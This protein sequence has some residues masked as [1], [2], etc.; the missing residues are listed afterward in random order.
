MRATITF[1]LLFIAGA[2]VA[3][4]WAQG[5]GNAPPPAHS[6]PPG[7]RSLAERMGGYRQAQ[8]TPAPPL[9][10]EEVEDAP[11][12]LPAPAAA[13]PVAPSHLHTE[14]NAPGAP[15]PLTIFLTDEQ[16]GEIMTTA[17]EEEGTLERRL[18]SIRGSKSPSPSPAPIAGPTPRA[19]GQAPTPATAAPEESDTDDG[20]RRVSVLR[21]ST[22]EHGSGNEPTPLT[23]S[24]ARPIG[25]TPAS[26]QDGSGASGIS[27]R[28]I[29]PHV[30][31]QETVTPRP[32]Q[33][34]SPSVAATPASNAIFSSSG[35]S[36]S[37]EA[38]GPKTLSVGKP[39]TYTIKLNNNGSATADEVMVFFG[40]PGS[41]EVGGLKS[42]AGNPAQEEIEGGGTRLQWTLDKL[43]AK[44]QET[45]QLTLTAKDNRPVALEAGW[46]CRPSFVQSQIEVQEPKLQ[47]SLS[48]P[49]EVQ[50][51]E[52]KI[53][54]IQL[55]NPGNGD[56]EN[57]TLQLIPST[58]NQ[59][60]QQPTRIGTLA[61]GAKKQ[62]E[63]EL[64]AREAGMVQI[65]VE[66]AA[67]GMLKSE[68][69]EQ[70]LVRRAKLQ[71]V[72]DA[73]PLKYAG[74]TAT[75]VFHVGNTGDSTASN[76]TATL[77]LPTGVVLENAGEGRVDARSG[78]ITWN[79]GTLRP[80]TERALE[81]TCLM[82]QS[83]AHKFDMHVAG[84]GDLSTHGLAT[85]EVE[86]LADLKLVVNDPAGPLPVGKEAEYQ[87]RIHN[88]GTKAAERVV[89]KALF[90]DGVDI[91]RVGGGRGEIAKGSVGFAPI[92]RINPG[93]EVTL[94]VT[95]Q[96]FRMGSHVFRAE[97]ECVEPETRLASQ[98][99]TRFYGDVPQNARRL[100][101]PTPALGPTP[102][103]GPT[104]QFGPT[105]SGPKFR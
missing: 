101:A 63:V 105:P 51:G 82:N 80:G 65:R 104:P 87:I 77:N 53:Y 76:I 58:G 86:A 6:G 48:G 11:Q 91:L 64:T 40:L 67:D 27:S 30:K 39:I 19:A 49:R 84:D 7:P 85:T 29:V 92:P 13:R 68:A 99:T 100:D 62:I 1:A 59:A 44:G 21:K 4:A 57:V 20:Q 8:R 2:V 60:P 24:G 31:P 46:T 75:Y 38:I 34:Q 26:E 79:L 16:P 81:V 83:G 28:R 43:A 90:S 71:V 66:A 72:V 78:R 36:L 47:V 41:V 73:A 55:T 54:M 35:A 103:G 102:A 32:L 56:A 12:L 18:R 22:V 5:G 52:T 96:A 70:V 37:V 93:Q 9:E 33:V 17:G 95:A 45:L 69:Q 88:R 89:V 94:T 15:A 74:S 25:P 23:P 42:S 98:E 50:Y 3:G 14:L 61:A 10:S 97:V